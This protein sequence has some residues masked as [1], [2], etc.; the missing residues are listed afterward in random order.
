MYYNVAL[1]KQAYDD[2]LKETNRYADNV[3]KL[4]ATDSLITQQYHQL[5]NGKWN[6]LM[7]QTHIGYT[8]WQQPNRQKMPTVQYLPA[9]SAVAGK[10]LTAP[11]S[12]WAKNAG[13]TGGTVFYQDEK[14]GV[15][16]EADHY[17]KA[18]NTNGITWK[19]LPDHGRTGSAI[20]P[21]PVTANEQKPG[22]NAPHLQYDIVADSAGK[23]VVD[24]YF[25][26]TLNLFRDENGLQYAISVDD[27]APQIVSLNKEDKTSDKGI[28][29]KWV[30]ESI[31]IK[32]TTHQLDKPGKHTVKFWMVNPGVVLQ[33]LVLDFG[34]QEKSYL[35]PEETVRR[36]S[37][38]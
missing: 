26:P 37:E 5:N 4:Y 36:I 15:S 12:K 19:I 20:T 10:D 3:K 18:I 1:N 24:A 7:S 35:G 8:Y 11:D 13:A 9:D 31:I 29:G 27:E 38:K 2:K 33:K 23:F 16:I 28:W 14:K 30:S 17:T 6:H 32:S 22:G 21:F 34:N 25:S